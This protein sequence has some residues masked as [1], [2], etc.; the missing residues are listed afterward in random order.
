MSNIYKVFAKVLQEG[1][2]KTLDENQPMEQAGFRKNFSTIDHIH[3]VKQIIQ[4]CNEY[5]KPLYVAFIDYSKAFDTLNHNHICKS[6]SSIKL[7][8]TGHPFPINRGVRQGGPLSPKLFSAVLESIF[9][10]IDW[11]G[12]GL[13]IN[14]CR[15]NHLR[16]ADDIVLFEE[17]PKKLELMIKDLAAKSKEVGLERNK[18]KTKHVDITINGDLFDYVTEYVYL[19]QIISPSDQMTKEINKRIAYGWKKYWSLKEVI[20]SKVLGIHLKRKTFDICILLCLT[21]GCETW[22]LTKFHR[23]KLSKCQRAMERST[24]GVKLKDKIRN[25]DIRD[26]K[27]K[28]GRQIRRWEDEIRQTLGPLWT[29]V[30]LDRAQWRMEEAFAKRHIEIRDIL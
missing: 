5:Q 17:D 9:R 22:S 23:E 10:S 13:N 28:R 4:K 21:Y 25:D 11:T 2:S 7:E 12:L 16:F 20:K 29:R 6:K 24:L 8:E 18:N 27:R 26:G 30:A 14:G 15:L 1:I 3:T 19:G